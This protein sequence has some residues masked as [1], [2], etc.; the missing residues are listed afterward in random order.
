MKSSNAIYD[1]NGKVVGKIEAGWIEKVNIDP[2]KH[3]LR[4]PEG[5]ATDA[6][7][8]SKLINGTDAKGIRLK[9]IDGTVLEA[10]IEDIDKHA[11]HINRGYGDQLVLPMRWW[12]IA[13][14]P[15]QSRMF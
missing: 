7:H 6:V 11:A 10:N 2:A 5:Y 4:S 8:I 13:S 1:N 14:D 15:R 9:L 12:T 3:K